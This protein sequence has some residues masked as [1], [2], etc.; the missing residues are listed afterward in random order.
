MKKLVMYSIKQ[1]TIR[2]YAVIIA[3]MILT[4]CSAGVEASSSQ[5]NMPEVYSSE[6]SEDDEMYDLDTFMNYQPD[7]TWDT[8][9]EF[10]FSWGGF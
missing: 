3:S 10:V 2:F 6:T 5:I 4:G 9:E 7:T 1:I 8:A